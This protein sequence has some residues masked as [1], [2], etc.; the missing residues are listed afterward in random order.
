LL[1]FSLTTTQLCQDITNPLKIC[2]LFL[3]FPHQLKERLQFRYITLATTTCVHD[4][5]TAL[6]TNSN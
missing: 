6:V 4:S 2:V 1:G 3:F 5:L